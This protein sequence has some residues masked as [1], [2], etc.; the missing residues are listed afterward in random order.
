[1]ASRRPAANAL[2]PNA[3]PTATNTAAIK[4][5]K[6]LKKSGGE[7]QASHRALQRKIRTVSPMPANANPATPPTI[8]AVVAVA[9]SK[10]LGSFGWVTPYFLP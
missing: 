10:F 9:G 4:L 3:A 8:R 6:I 2:K 5:P 7:S 1:M